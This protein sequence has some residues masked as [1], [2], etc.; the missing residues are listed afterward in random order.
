MPLDGFD[1]EKKNHQIAWCRQHGGRTA[2]GFTWDRSNVVC[3]RAEA[4]IDL[5]P[6]DVTLA[7]RLV[8]LQER[9]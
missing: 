6:A 5:P 2:M 4:V 7:P 3:L 9:K 8:E 1:V